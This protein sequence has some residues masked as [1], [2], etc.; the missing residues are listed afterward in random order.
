[1]LTLTMYSIDPSLFNKLS[2]FFIY[3]GLSIFFSLNSCFLA[4]FKFMTS[5]VTLLSNNASTVIPSYILIFSN[6][7]FTVTFLNISP[8]FRL[9]LDIFSTTLLS[10]ANL[11]VLESNQRL[12]GSSS[13]LNSS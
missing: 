1:M 9:Q 10:I 7:I 4:N 2:M 5:L 12:L 13:Y 3:I 11:F 8:L 6:P